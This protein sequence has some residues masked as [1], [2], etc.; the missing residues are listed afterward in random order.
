[1]PKLYKAKKIKG[2]LNQP[3]LNWYI[4]LKLGDPLKLPYGPLRSN[5]NPQLVYDSD[6]KILSKITDPVDI[7]NVASF[8]QLILYHW[9]YFEVFLY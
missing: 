2:K 4:K 7:D 6:F 1:M 3:R 8:G 5:P 9:I